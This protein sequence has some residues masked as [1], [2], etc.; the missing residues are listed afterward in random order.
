MNP[1]DPRHV[2]ERFI[3]ACG[4]DGTDPWQL[5]S[6]SAV[7]TVAGST[8]FSGRFEGQQQ[9]RRI[10]IETFRQYLLAPRI[11][12]LD[13]IAE[14]SHVGALIEVSGTSRDGRRF[15]VAGAAW[16]AAFMLAGDR[17]AAIEVF[18]DTMFLETALCGAIYEP[19]DPARVLT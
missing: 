11:R 14:G 6:P 17:I 10:L 8:W 19:N 4:G 7:V 13:L 9:I 2:V 5:L 16:G 3:A 18:P 1:V 12:V 15:S